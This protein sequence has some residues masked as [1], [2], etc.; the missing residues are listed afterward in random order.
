ML[1]GSEVGSPIKELVKVLVTGERIGLHSFAPKLCLDILGVRHYVDRNVDVSQHPHSAPEIVD[2]LQITTRTRIGQ[3]SPED[4]M[5]FIEVGIVTV[6]VYLDEIRH[7]LCRSKLVN[8]RMD[9]M[10][11]F[12]HL[13]ETVSK[14]C[15]E[16]ATRLRLSE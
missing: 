7:I 13:F 11:L 4:L 16:L 3:E 9:S 12:A 6:P 5:E 15:V 8:A 2:P 1:F 14:I 10:D